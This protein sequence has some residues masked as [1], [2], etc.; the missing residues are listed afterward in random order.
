M[1]VA[2]EAL[3]VEVEQ[4]LAKTTELMKKAPRGK[5][6]AAALAMIQQ[7]ATA[8]AQTLEEAKTAHGAGEFARANDLAKSVLEKANS[9]ITE[10]ETAI[11]KK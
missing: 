5:D 6:G 9:L 1:R 3:I 8:A 10:L 4:A 7:D 11:A 2:N